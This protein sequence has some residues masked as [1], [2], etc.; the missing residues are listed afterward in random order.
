M[1]HVQG[2]RT[3]AELPDIDYRLRMWLCKVAKVS[4]HEIDRKGG[5]GFN[6][7]FSYIY[8]NY[9]GRLVEVLSQSSLVEET[10][11]NP[12]VLP[13]RLL[14]FATLGLPHLI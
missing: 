2:C 12:V 3:H 13:T 5:K 7:K 6:L 9:L 8:H 4:L 1:L 14:L 10:L 11:V